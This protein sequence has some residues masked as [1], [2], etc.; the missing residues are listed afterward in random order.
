MTRPRRAAPPLGRVP[1][2]SARR[3]LVGLLS[4]A[5]SAD[6]RGRD[7]PVHR[8][9]AVARSLAQLRPRHRRGAHRPH[10][11]LLTAA[12]ACGRRAVAVFGIAGGVLLYRFALLRRRVETWVAALAAAPI[13]LAYPLFL[14][15]F[16]RSARPSS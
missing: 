14:V 13:V 1:A 11:F 3:S 7:Q 9:A 4:R 10:R 12:S 6:P 5:G 15:I 2:G 16:G 8:A